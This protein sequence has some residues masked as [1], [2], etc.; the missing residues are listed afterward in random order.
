MASSEDEFGPIAQPQ[1]LSLE[2]SAAPGQTVAEDSFGPIPAER[3]AAD[4]SL[5][6]G[7]DA[8]DP[9]KAQAIP[10]LKYGFT[11]TL[12]AIDRIGNRFL[13]QAVQEIGQKI[14]LQDNPL[15]APLLP[16]KGYAPTGVAENLLS[17]A[18][19]FADPA[20]LAVNLAI[21]GP[22]GKAVSE[23]FEL[24][25]TLSRAEST[26]LSRGTNQTVDLLYKASRAEKVARIGTEGA[27]QGLYAGATDA[28]SS[29]KDPIN[30][31]AKIAASTALGGLGG[32]A[33]GALGAKIGKQSK[34]DLERFK[35]RST[36]LATELQ[37]DLEQ[38]ALQQAKIQQDLDILQE[39]KPQRAL[40][41]RLQA[42]EQKG[43]QSLDSASQAAANVEFDSGQRLATTLNKA[44]A[45]EI[46]VPFLIED[47]T[48]KVV[49]GQ[50]KLALNTQAVSDKWGSRIS[51]VDEEIG[52]VRQQ[53]E[54]SKLSHEP[55]E[56][57]FEP[58]QAMEARIRELEAKKVQLTGFANEEH[59]S[60]STSFQGHLDDVEMQ[61]DAR[62]EKLGKSR[63]NLLLDAAGQEETA[64]QRL[65]RISEAASEKQNI[66]SIRKEGIFAQADALLGKTKDKY[67]IL[68][69]KLQRNLE[70]QMLLQDHAQGLGFTAVRAKKLLP[71]MLDVAQ[72]Q[73]E[74]VDSAL[75]KGLLSDS[76]AARLRTLEW[77]NA[78]QLQGVNLSKEAVPKGL[79]DWVN[80]T[81]QF[82]R[83]DQKL[84][85]KTADVVLDA[86]MAH[87]EYRNFLVDQWPAVSE[88]S[89]R[90]SGLG[91][92]ADE[93]GRI[94]QYIESGEAG[95]Y[96]DPSPVQS[97][98]LTRPAYQ[99]PQISPE[100]L[101]E[102]SQIRASFDALQTI[103]G[104]GKARGYVP[105]REMTPGK[106]PLGGRVQNITDPTFA[107]GRVAGELLPGV[108]EQNILK[109]WDRYTR[110][111][112]RHLYYT[113]ILEKG[114]GEY[115]KLLLVG[116]E[117]AAKDFLKYM[118][119]TLGLN[120]E[121]DVAS[122]LGSKAYSSNRDLIFQAAARLPD[123]EGFLSQL[124]QEVKQ[125]TYQS[126]VSLNPK[127]LLKQA[128]QPEIMGGAEI[129]QANMAKGR[130]LQF[131]K[132][133]REPAVRLLRKSM[134]ENLPEMAD[135]VLRPGSKPANI[136]IKGL[137]LVTGLGEKLSKPYALAE[138]QNRM[139]SL[140]GSLFQA[141][142]A[143][144]KD[145]SIGLLNLA[146][147]MTQA[148]Q[149]LVRRALDSQGEQ[150]GKEMYALL[151]TRRI[152]FV[153]DITDR[154]EILNADYA[155]MIPF[156]GFARGI[157]TRTIEDVS[158]GNI[159]RLAKRIAIPIVANQI[160][161]STVGYKVPGLNPYN[162]GNV[163][164]PIS[165]S[166]MPGVVDAAEELAKSG[167]VVKAGKQLVKITPLGTYE[168]MQRSMKRQGNDAANLFG[169]E[170]VGTSRK[171]LKGV[172]E[173]LLGTR[174]K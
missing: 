168:N 101:A 141:G 128:F 142:K 89:K 17:I 41:E 169:A 77:N 150:A 6:Q 170:K 145:G 155:R 43:A 117:G 15:V 8:F 61:L 42:V 56:T 160:L 73:V 58:Q 157:I 38:K 133:Y 146:K 51:A 129:G 11:N 39:F 104:A 98:S 22:A 162:V 173:D 161:E 94:L 105:L 76:Q 134:S 52:Q 97:K 33:L 14:E 135:E 12:R 60:L 124:G 172:K 29:E 166:I 28:I 7:I 84:G 47:T 66:N 83:Y 125:L 131:A 119:R 95:A 109:L 106:V 63:D 79:G 46:S 55:I 127:A 71:Q 70:E 138:K 163:A 137:R 75:A 159:A 86:G 93:Q 115:N 65:L 148:E 53:L 120:T 54:T 31:A 108:H 78:I 144:E 149:R 136:I 91:Y 34:L 110:E 30:I 72:Q 1:T 114:L 3:A 81:L 165:G 48:Q 18:G 112:G 122:L 143:V 35:F 64:N 102:F 171:L 24:G 158:S 130:A 118:G 140:V 99:G 85:T 10:A 23:A 25:K 96:F 20:Q 36:P 151:R 26:F 156:T 121:K 13:P 32:A 167:D 113:P 100:A 87:H 40:Q 59:G 19:S 174:P 92:S 88:S 147:G 67:H 2:Q 69:E 132:E 27:V 153:Y 80:R 116:Q 123:Q 164:Q 44:T 90:L 126:L 16:P 62:I 5:R 21:A 4:A 9:N 74:K 45:K 82:G 50:E 103:N 139:V 152:N 68:Q 154:P 57:R 107:E 37:Q 49:Q 111:V